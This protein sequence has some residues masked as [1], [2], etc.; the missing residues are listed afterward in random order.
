MTLASILLTIT[1]LVL[2]WAPLHGHEIAYKSGSLALATL[3]QFLVA[4][5]FYPKALKALVFSRVIEM[6]LLI[7]LSPSAAYVFSVVSF[8]FL[9]T[10]EPLSTGNF[11]QTSTLLVTLI[12]SV[13]MWRPWLVRKPFNTAILVDFHGDHGREIDTRL[14]QLGDIF[15]VMP[16]SRIPTDGTTLAGT[17]EMDES[18]VTGE[19]RP[20]VKSPGSPQRIISTVRPC[21]RIPGDNTIDTTAAMVDGAKLSKPTMQRLTDRVASYFVPVISLLMIITFAIWIAVGIRVRGVSAREA[22]IEAVTY[23]ITV[24]IVC[25][26]CAISLAVP[27]VV[28][29]ATGVGA[30]H[31]VVFKSA[32]SIEVA[33][34]AKY[35]ILD[36]TGTLTRLA[37]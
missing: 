35:V 17:S 23:A 11:F 18:M 21:T 15:K 31:G 33:Y 22:I 28:V 19:S 20:V 5:P 30:E 7:V 13:A 10:G 26:P 36:K 27:M 24:L 37:L 9:V 8:A 3:V 2:A 6:D 4:G 12:M 29:I 25:C 14:L 1:V 16:E 34:Q 32:E